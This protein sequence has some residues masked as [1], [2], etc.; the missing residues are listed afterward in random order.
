[1]D[2]IPLPVCRSQYVDIFLWH[3]CFYLKLR[4][5]LPLDYAFSANV[6]GDDC[7]CLTSG[8]FREKERARTNDLSP[9]IL[10]WY[11]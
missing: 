9:P 4:K 6:L 5:R 8:I 1:M 7:A 11:P 2:A 10:L 3:A